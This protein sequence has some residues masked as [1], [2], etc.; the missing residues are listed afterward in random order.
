M[1][2]I[3]L[4]SLTRDNWHDCANLKVADDQQSFVAPNLVSIAQSQFY[5]GTEM[6]AIYADS[7]MV[8][9]IMWIID[10]E[11]RPTRE[12]WIWRFMIAAEHQRQGYGRAALRQVIDMLKAQGETELF[13][14]YEPENTG[15]A[16]FYRGFGFA[17]TGRIEHGEIVVRL[18]MQGV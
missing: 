7:E 4:R 9:F 8:G 2:T 13:L 1:T 10:T 16:A 5:P 18:D 11:Q 14:S 17:E 3:E 15:G 12:L 6:R